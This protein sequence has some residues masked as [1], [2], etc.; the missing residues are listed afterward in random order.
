MSRSGLVSHSTSSERPREE[1]FPKHSRTVFPGF[2][3]CSV[4]LL[5]P[6]SQG[7][8]GSAGAGPGQQLPPSVLL[9]AGTC[10]ECVSRA[11]RS[12]VTMFGHGGESQMGTRGRFPGNRE[13]WQPQLPAGAQ[14][15]LFG[16]GAGAGR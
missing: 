16:V 14:A 4:L 15:P 10:S 8:L 7:T 2:P 9:R 11:V 1:V 13:G 6:V 5:I 3:A 12:D